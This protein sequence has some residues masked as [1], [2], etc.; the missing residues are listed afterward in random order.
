MQLECII[1]GKNA[2]LLLGVEKINHNLFYMMGVTDPDFPF[3]EKLFLIF[4]FFSIL[5]NSCI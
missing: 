5:Q 2:T 4:F 3:W 1:I